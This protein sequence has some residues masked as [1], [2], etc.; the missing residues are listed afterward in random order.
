MAPLL[1]RVQ[2]ASTRMDAPRSPA[3]RGGLGRRPDLCLFDVSK[4]SHAWIS[5]RAPGVDRFRCHWERARLSRIHLRELLHAE[6]VLER[7]A[8]GFQE[9]EE[10][11]GGGWIPAPPEQYWRIVFL[12]SVL[13]FS[14]IV[15]LGN[16]EVQVMNDPLR[17]LAYSD[18]M[19]ERTGERPHEGH[20]FPNAVGFPEVP[21]VAKERDR[22]RLLR[23]GPYDMA[24]TLD[25]GV[26]D[27]ERLCRTRDVGREELQSGAGMWL[28]S[29][30]HP[31]SLAEIA[32]RG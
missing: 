13:R 6:T 28:Q 4:L 31:P 32:L 16:H 11:T 1:L 10:H 18:A 17:T 25:F 8:V 30:R 24:E 7:H 2:T 23:N 9:V 26:G 14:D 19:M 29:T 21:H 12:R 15:D 20:D 5:D 3:V 27:R 22:F